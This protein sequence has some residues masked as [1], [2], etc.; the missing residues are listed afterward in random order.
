[1]SL[2]PLFC[3]CKRFL[4]IPYISAPH[5]LS[6]DIFN[7]LI[8][9]VYCSFAVD[10]IEEE[11]APLTEALEPPPVETYDDQLNLA[12]EAT[13]ELGWIHILGTVPCLYYVQEGY[14]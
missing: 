7:T 9:H 1:M 13:K 2:Q 6:N 10:E 4:N 12:R 5:A 11:L 8:M 14:F 3:L